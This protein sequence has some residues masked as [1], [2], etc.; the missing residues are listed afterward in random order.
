MRALLFGSILWIEFGQSAL[1]ETAPKDSRHIVVI[2]W[3]G[4]R[5]D[6]VTPRNTPTLW[7]LAREGVKFRN[8]HAVYPSATHVN[9]TALVT[10]VYPGHSG[11]IANYDYRPD[12][13][14]KRFVSTEQLGVITKGDEI[15]GGKY[16]NVPTIA[17]R[18]RAAGG[19]TAIASAKTV[20]F[21]LDRQV[22]AGAA[23]KGVT[24]SA[25]DSLP[26]DALAAI[27][28]EHGAFPGWPM[29]RHVQRDA[30]TT[31]ALVDC[32]WKEA[33]PNFSLLW[34]G[35]PDLTQ[36]ESAPGAPPAIAAIKSADQ[37]LAT[38]I[39][40]LEEKAV[41]AATDIF[42]VSDHG[43]STIEH[44]V[45]LKKI[46]T[47][48][49]FMA[50]TEFKSE[51]KPGDI[52]LVG[53]GGTVLFYI[54]G[55]D[56]AVT[57]RLVEFLQKSDFA[58]AI[59]TKELLPGTFRFDQAQ[60]E[61]SRGPDVAMAFRWNI[62]KNR[63]GVP[64]AIDADW[65]RQEGKG[66][67]ATLSRFDMHNMLIA[68][69]PDLRRGE[70]DDLPTGNVDIAP[71]ILHILGMKSAPEFD[72]RVLV[73]AMTNSNV[74]PPKP[75]SETIDAAREWPQ[76]TWRQSIRISRV[77]ATTYIDEGNGVFDRKQ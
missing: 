28:S 53:N 72:G 70:S 76:G 61:S 1:A 74:A 26:P 3:D 16:L 58:G 40:K 27:L 54:I 17:E 44:A 20:G 25:G 64:G 23:A 37:N 22:D 71:T 45:D 33:L 65:N 5:P 11:V 2:V 10:G 39:S 52:M 55:H 30:W 43:F 4:M 73:E 13:D 57:A 77:G 24:L 46:L 69:G 62:S 66:T 41:R 51:P 32:L 59:F 9:G 47:N 63:F 19:R 50:M 60:I 6:F 35:E 18:V 31:K 15:S 49:G 56:V 8:H 68:A 34:L 7:R 14:R 48:A 75:K 36:H 12:I 42:I 67:H 21:L 29:Y 38:V